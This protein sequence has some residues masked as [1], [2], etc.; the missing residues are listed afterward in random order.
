MFIT[1]LTFLRVQPMSFF[2]HSYELGI[3]L[4]LLK[5]RS[6]N[7]MICNIDDVFSLNSKFDDYVDRIYLIKLEIKAT[8]DITRST[9]YLYLQI[10]VENEDRLRTKL[11][12]KRA[13]YNFRM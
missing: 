8:T 4:G 1:Q 13:D 9:S 12:E 10:D 6:Y 2:Q 5:S 3:M 11:I 7:F